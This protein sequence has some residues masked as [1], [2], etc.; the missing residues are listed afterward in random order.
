MSNRIRWRWILLALVPGVLSILIFLASFLVSMSAR[1][2]PEVA[3]VV[4]GVLWAML[5]LP[6]AMPFYLYFLGRKYVRA[7]HAGLKSAIPFAILYS[8]A[9]LMLWACGA[10]FV[11]SQMRTPG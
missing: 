5:C 9:N 1:N 4:M 11:M 6:L 8:I 2:S 10:A 7:E 3:D